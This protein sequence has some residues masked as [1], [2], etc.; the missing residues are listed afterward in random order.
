MTKIITYQSFLKSILYL[1]LV[2]QLWANMASYCNWMPNPESDLIELCDLESD[3]S[4]EEE[5]K[6][7]RDDKLRIDL[8]T[9]KFDDTTTSIKNRIQTIFLLYS[10]QNLSF[11]HPNLSAPKVFLSL[12][13]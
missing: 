2:A 12:L 10:I 13:E 11:P 6:K 9:P 4:E 1:L 3:E 7:E 5:N 8:D